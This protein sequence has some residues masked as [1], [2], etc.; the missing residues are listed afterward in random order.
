MTRVGS[1]TPEAEAVMT[2]SR[3]STAED[4]KERFFADA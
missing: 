4:S 3:R 1:M 2:I